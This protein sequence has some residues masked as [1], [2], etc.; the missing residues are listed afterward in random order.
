MEKAGPQPSH[1]WPPNSMD[2]S[3]LPIKV[4]GHEEPIMLEEGGPVFTYVKMVKL[5][6]QAEK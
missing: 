3:Q 5:Q 1:L 4:K 2:P 6:S